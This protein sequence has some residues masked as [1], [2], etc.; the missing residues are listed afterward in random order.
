VEI[1]RRL[2]AGLQG[3]RSRSWPGR[4]RSS[5]Q[6]GIPADAPARPQQQCQPAGGRPGDRCRGAS[7]L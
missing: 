2:E 6:G 1:A 3:T 4:P 5:E 7:G